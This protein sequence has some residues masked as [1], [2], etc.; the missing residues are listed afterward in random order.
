MSNIKEIAEQLVNLSVKEVNELAMITK[1]NM[2]I[3]Q[4]RYE[5]PK[6]NKVLTPK[7]YGQRK[8]YKRFKV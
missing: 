4:V 1:H 5:E 6:Y 7:Q 3:P 8:I 2:D